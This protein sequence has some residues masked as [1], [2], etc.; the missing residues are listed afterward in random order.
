[1]NKIAL[2]LLIIIDSFYASN[3]LYKQSD[4]SI[5]TILSEKEHFDPASV[6]QPLPNKTESETLEYI[7]DQIGKNQ[8]PLLIFDCYDL[9]ITNN[10]TRLYF[11]QNIE[12]EKIY[13]GLSWIA[14][15]V[16]KRYPDNSFAQI[17]A[18]NYTKGHLLLTKL[19]MRASYLQTFDIDDRKTIEKTYNYFI[20]NTKP[21]I[22]EP[23]NAFEGRVN[24]YYNQNFTNIIHILDQNLLILKKSA[25]EFLSKKVPDLKTF[26]AQSTQKEKLEN[27]EKAKQEHIKQL[28]HKITVM[29]SL[30]N[31]LQQS[32]DKNLETII[33]ND[34]HHNEPQKVNQ[35]KNSLFRL[36][37]ICT[38]LTISGILIQIYFWTC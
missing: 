21:E 35:N 19:H 30:T 11:K 1:M 38:W 10:P 24:N 2:S 22:R 6:I 3:S 4:S 31:N 28:E 26:D 29:K 7:I 32:F 15:E 17:F 37:K 8:W 20:S 34:R 16:R 36:L 33:E 5:P 18:I 12:L 13:D 14:E 25:D 27:I 9:K 23:L